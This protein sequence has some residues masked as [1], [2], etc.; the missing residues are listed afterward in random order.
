[1]PADHVVALG[2]QLLEA[3]AGLMTPIGIERQLE[4]PFVR[5]V[6]RLEE[7]RGL[8]DV[9]QHGHVEPRARLPDRIELR[10]VDLQAAAVGFPIEHP[11]ILEDL[12][13]H[14]AR[15]D[16]FFELAS[17]LLAESGSGAGAEVDVREQHHAV[18]V[19]ARFDR[20]DPA[21]QPI[22]R[23]AA[24]I[25]QHLKVVGLHAFHHALEFACQ[26]R[27]RL[28]AVHVDHGELRARNRVLR[29]DELRLRLVLTNGGR[30][31]F[32][33][34]ALG[35]TRPNLLSAFAAWIARGRGHPNEGRREHDEQEFLHRKDRSEP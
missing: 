30:P 21:V 33:V 35:G 4:P 1:M 32:R 6:E 13:A 16:V 19:L 22:A 12:Q 31:E 5:V 18:A 9:N 25:H 29:R 15:I 34:A 2:H 3:D 27:R 10:I 24:Q 26:D 8:G 11:Q 14:R 20:L 7:C 17:G 23:R 28:M